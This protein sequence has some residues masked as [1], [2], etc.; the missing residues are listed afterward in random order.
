MTDILKSLTRHGKTILFIE[1]DMKTVTGISDNIIV[2][3][4]GK[5]IAEGIPEQI[6][7]NEKV[8]EAYLG[9]RRCIIVS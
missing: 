8:I 1:H 2:L 4:Y 6:T 3:D 5:K 7:A 9:K